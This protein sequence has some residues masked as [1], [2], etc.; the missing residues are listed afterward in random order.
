MFLLKSTIFSYLLILFSIFSTATVFA[1]N[2]LILTSAPR[3]TPEK[4]EQLYG[5]IAAHL[6]KALG[7]K[8]RYEHPGNWLSYQNNMR[9][10]KYDIIFDGPHF[11]SWRIVH[12]GHEAL[13]KLPGTLQFMMVNDKDDQVFDSATKLVGKKICGISPPNL[14]TLTV[15]DYY[16]NPVRQPIIKGIKGGMG[17]VYKTFIEQKGL[18]NAAVLRT[19]FYKKKLKQADR[20]KLKTLFL[21]KAMPNQ[22]I[23]VSKRVDQRSKGII[24]NE[25]LGKGAESAKGL[26]KRFAGK[27]NGFIAVEKNEYAGYNLLLEGVIFGW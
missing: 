8:V 13:V 16:R 23:S 12:L 21:S 26:F 11:I 20:D 18:C 19:T 15:L 22:G 27:A 5:P 25:L 2:E 10:D 1:N 3:E 7:V 4:G 14:S 17:K 24:V 9:S 6:S